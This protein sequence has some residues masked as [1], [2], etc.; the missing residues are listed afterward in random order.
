[1]LPPKPTSNAPAD[2]A[3]FHAEIVKLLKMDA[4]YTDSAGRL[5][6]RSDRANLQ[7]LER[8]WK[9]RAAGKDARWNVVGAKPG[10][11]FRELEDQYRVPVPIVWDTDD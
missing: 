10:R 11:A 8:R 3:A 2:A 7:R 6:T 1:M 5:F 9:K 4:T